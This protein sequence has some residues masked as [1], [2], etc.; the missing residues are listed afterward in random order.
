MYDRADEDPN[1]F[2]GAPG[3]RYQ[4]FARLLGHKAALGTCMHA[5]DAKPQEDGSVQLT[6]RFGTSPC[7]DRE[8][9][10]NV[11]TSPLL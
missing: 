11:V 3:G 9:L 2:R 6:P 8:G 5:A 4:C 10:P 1:A 7:L